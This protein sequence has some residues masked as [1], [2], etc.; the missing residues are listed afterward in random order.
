L[1]VKNQ[2]KGTFEAFRSTLV[3]QN[4]LNAAEVIY[5]YFVKYLILNSCQ[6]LVSLFIHK[7]FS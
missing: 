4:D 5:I 6:L 1:L 7:C 2:N 3:A